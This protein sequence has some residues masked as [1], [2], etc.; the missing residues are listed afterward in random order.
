MGHFLYWIHLKLLLKLLRSPKNCT[1]PYKNLLLVY[2]NHAKSCSFQDCKKF[3]S[4]SCINL[5]AETIFWQFLRRNKTFTQHIQSAQVNCFKSFN[6]S[7]IRYIW[8]QSHNISYNQKEIFRKIAFFNFFPKSSKSFQCRAI[9]FAW[10]IWGDGHRTQ[11]PVQWT[12][13]C[14]K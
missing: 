4:I 10:P 13:Y 9:H 1:N 8:I 5:Q 6:S 14:L 3:T 7:L 11:I 2:L 12:L